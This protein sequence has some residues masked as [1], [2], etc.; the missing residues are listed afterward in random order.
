MRDE[1]IGTPAQAPSLRR[2]LAPQPLR[3]ARSGPQAPV[4]DRLR[5]H[6]LAPRSRRDG[7]RGRHPRELSSPTRGLDAGRVTASRWIPGTTSQVSPVPGPRI[8]RELS[9]VSVGAATRV[10][11][12]SV[13]V[14]LVVGDRDGETATLVLTIRLDGLSGGDGET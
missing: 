14:P 7:R 8:S 13:R 4:P 6:R 11:D 12:R 10:D 1:S 5:A 3:R 2:A 9:I